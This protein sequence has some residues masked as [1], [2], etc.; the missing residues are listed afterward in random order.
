[1]DYSSPVA[2][3]CDSSGDKEKVRELFQRLSADASG[4]GVGFELAEN[5][6]EHGGRGPNG[7]ALSRSGGAVR[8]FPQVEAVRWCLTQGHWTRAS[9]AAVRDGPGEAAERQGF[10]QFSQSRSRGR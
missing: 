9:E 4:A 6:E 8:L 10:V 1:M 3:L 5:G 7:L 2:L